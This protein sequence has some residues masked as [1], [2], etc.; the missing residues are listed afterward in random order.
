MRRHL[1]IPGLTVLALTQTPGAFAGTEFDISADC[2]AGCQAAFEG[3]VEDIS[4]ALNYKALAPAEATGL[5]G[6][7]IG[8]FMT[9]TPVE[10]DDAWKQLTGSNVD[11]VGMAGVSVAK[12]LPFGID[13]GAFYTAVPDTSVKAYG[14]EIRY[15]ILEGGIAE[16]A[17]AVRGAYT[18]TS[19]IDDFDYEAYSL[20][21]SLSKGFTFLT[22]YIGAGYVW[23]TA[24]P[25]GSV[26]EAPL[27]LSEVEVDKSRIYAGLRIAF[28]PF[29]LTPQYERQGD[30]SSYSL[31]FGFS[32]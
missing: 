14:A 27:N 32:F 28:I 20:D 25:S 8:A 9:Y 11:F 15:A 10:N 24:T 5:L 6:I 3:A 7:G 19:G 12:G 26:T 13:V 17:L 29:E 30:N 21:V 16:P 2:G 22:P 4:A 31:R 18:G 23:A 1:L